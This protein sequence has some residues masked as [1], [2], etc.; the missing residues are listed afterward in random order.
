MMKG[1]WDNSHKYSNEYS[2]VSQDV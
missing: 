2:E 1:D